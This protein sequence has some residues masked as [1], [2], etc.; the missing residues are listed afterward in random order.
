MSRLLLGCALGRLISAIA[1]HT[2]I[3]GGNCGLRPE[4]AIRVEPWNESAVPARLVGMLRSTLTPEPAKRYI[5]FSTGVCSELRVHLT[6]IPPLDEGEL[7]L[8]Q[9][10]SAW[11]PTFEP[12]GGCSESG[13]PPAR[14]PARTPII[15]AAVN[16]LPAWEQ[17]WYGPPDVDPDPTEIDPVPPDLVA[18]LAA[19][20]TTLAAVVVSGQKNIRC[21]EISRHDDAGGAHPPCRALS[22][23]YAR[24]ETLVFSSPPPWGHS[25]PRRINWEVSGTHTGAFAIDFECLDPNVR[26]AVDWGDLADLYTVAGAAE[27]EFVL[28]HAESG[29][30]TS[31]GGRNIL[32]PLLISAMLLSAVCLWAD[33][34][35]RARTGTVLAS[36]IIGGAGYH[37]VNILVSIFQTKCLAYPHSRN[38]FVNGLTWN[39]AIALYANTWLMLSAAW[40]LW[41]KLGHAKPAGTGC[42]RAISTLIWV[43]ACPVRC[44]LE[45]A[46]TGCFARLFGIFTANIAEVV[47]QIVNQKIVSRWEFAATL[48]LHG[49]LAAL[50]VRGD[51]LDRDEWWSFLVVFDVY[52]YTWVV[53]LTVAVGSA[54]AALHTHG[55][56]DDNDP[57]ARAARDKARGGSAGDYAKLSQRDLVNR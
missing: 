26:R 32:Y 21:R 8:R 4:N 52:L 2:T 3:L 19:A 37:T 11:N 6:S 42:T 31:T 49:G 13:E 17:M 46:P 12:P 1:A 56:S 34:T 53:I 25:G 35:H 55:S 16:S 40:A 44:V 47:S 33:T 14:T 43:L 45:K 10:D 57:R 7:M 28:A 27:R 38:S 22:L 29:E 20:G 9:I 50:S 23:L 15:T 18:E 54:T 36:F 51:R 30:C 41:D 39:L 48:L 24:S 5:S